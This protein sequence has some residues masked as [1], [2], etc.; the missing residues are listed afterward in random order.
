MA[1]GIPDLRRRA[2]NVHGSN[3]VGPEELGDTRRRLNLLDL[4][5]QGTPEYGLGGTGKGSGLT[6]PGIIEILQL[7]LGGGPQ[8]QRD[9]GP[10]QRRGA[11]PQNYPQVMRDPITSVEPSN[12]QRAMRLGALE[13]VGPLAGPY[14]THNSGTLDSP[15]M[16]Y[17]P[18]PSRP[19]SDPL[20]DTKQ[21]TI[22]RDAPTEP[23]DMR[24]LPF[25]PRSLHAP[26]Q[27]KR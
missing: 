8:P 15:I 10:V 5:Q 13:R 19:M 24:S 6:T 7:L 16:H 12:A 22:R 11:G 20:L 14:M 2:E 26:E 25:L 1:N 9:L 18:V 3:P 17:A 4:Q 23:P 27:H 21:G